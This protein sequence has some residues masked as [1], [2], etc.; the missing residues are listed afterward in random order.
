LAKPGEKGVVNQAYFTKS[1]LNTNFKSNLGG[2]LDFEFLFN[3]IQPAL[4][5]GTSGIGKLYQTVS[6]DFLY[7]D[8]MTNVIFLDNHDM[9]RFFS[10]VGERVD[11][12]K[13]ALS[14]LLPVAAFR[15]CIMELKY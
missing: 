10:Q 1:N 8:P 4:T 13:M 6:L 5:Q 3:G 12:Q 14:W 7:K 11:K 2:V 15:K 9:T